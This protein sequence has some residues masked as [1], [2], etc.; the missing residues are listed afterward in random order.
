MMRQDMSPIDEEL[1]S[2]SIVQNN[3]EKGHMEVQAEE[4]VEELAF[5]RCPFW[6]GR[7][8]WTMLALGPWGALL[9]VKGAA[10]FGVPPTPNMF[11]GLGVTGFFVTVLL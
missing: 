9:F 7:L 10:Y 8:I 4:P 1:R 3:N 2:V 6:T 11:V 5:R